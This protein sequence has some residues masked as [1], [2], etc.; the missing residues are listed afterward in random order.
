VSE[1]DQAHG[2]ATVVQPAGQLVDRDLPVL[3]VG[4]DLD[5]DAEPAL[6]L[7]HAD[8]PGGVL[9]PRGEDP[10][11]GPQGQRPERLV[12]ADGG[13]LDQRDLVR[14]GSDERGDLVV[15]AGLLCGPGGGELVAAGDGLGPQPLDLSVQHHP[16]RQAAAGVV[17]VDDLGAARRVGP[18]QGDVD[19][20]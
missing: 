16:R 14:R 7:Q 11:A 18:G 3:V 4:H 12:P 13:V 17:E 19:P 5:G 2:P 8:E 6:G 10:V 9:G 20:T 15:G 1:G